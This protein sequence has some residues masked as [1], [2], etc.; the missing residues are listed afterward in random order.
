ME[1]VKLKILIKSFEN[2]NIE[3]DFENAVVEHE[4][5]KNIIDIINRKINFNNNN[6]AY[7]MVCLTGL[8]FGTDAWIE[9]V[10]Y[11]TCNNFQYIQ[12]VKN[13]TR[14]DFIIKL[15]ECKQQ[16]EFQKKEFYK[17]IDVYFKEINEIVFEKL[18]YV[19]SCHK[20]Y[21][22]LT[23]KCKNFSDNIVP[24]QLVVRFLFVVKFRA[25]YDKLYSTYLK[26]HDLDISMCDH[27]RNNT[28]KITN[29]LLA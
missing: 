26:I 2:Y 18:V 20:K 1:N 28:Y 3:S 5:E 10:K 24:Y 13:H 15:K 17:D 4:N 7:D 22:N 8:L 16:Y 25:E 9:Y 21:S 27:L 23:N 29:T 14:E 6:D 11:F 12:S 19:L